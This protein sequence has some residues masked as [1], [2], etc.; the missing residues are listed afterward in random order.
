[1]AE[2]VTDIRLVII[3]CDQSL[4]SEDVKGV[5]KVLMQFQTIF[6]KSILKIS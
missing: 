4:E 5:H 3:S 2:Q 1:M 6:V